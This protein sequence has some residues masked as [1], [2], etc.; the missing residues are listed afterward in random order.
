MSKLT[1]DK[2]SEYEKKET[3]ARK[4][5]VIKVGMSTCGVAAGAQEVF[6]VLKNTVRQRNLDI[7]VQKCGCG[8]K[9]YAEPMVEVSIEN[10]PVVVYGNVDKNFAV[11]II[12]RHIINKELLND[13]IYD[14][15]E[16]NGDK[17]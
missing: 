6:E 9:C 4:K 15:F 2:L 16:E 14:I 13:H 8:G 7:D 3:K 1:K 12:D 17:I 5:N 10:F 11:S